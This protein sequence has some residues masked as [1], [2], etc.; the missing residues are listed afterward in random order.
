MIVTHHSRKLRD[1]VLNFTCLPG[2]RLV[3]RSTLY[4]DGQQWSSG[5]PTCIPQPSTTFPSTVRAYVTTSSL[6]T[7]DVSTG[8]QQAD[9]TDRPV[10][11]SFSTGQSGHVTTDTAV[12]SLV[13]ST[14]A[15]DN[16]QSITTDAPLINGTGDVRASQEHHGT[17][18]RRLLWYAG[19]AGSC[20]L[21][22]MVVAA[23]SGVAVRRRARK[24]RR[25]QL[26]DVADDAGGG[27]GGE[28]S[29]PAVRYVRQYSEL[30]SNCLVNS[31][32]NV[33]APTQRLSS[34]SAADLSDS[35]SL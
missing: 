15:A 11:S 20:A 9:V 33:S 16:V 25:Y 21:L 8:G 17:G 13:A 2:F 22:L 5:W 28:W 27:A 30:T 35:T 10:T 14:S 32:E 7:T 34:H 29:S 12:I 1:M 31:E 18:A 24:M 4:C 23:A 19:V 26:M 6:V 3:G